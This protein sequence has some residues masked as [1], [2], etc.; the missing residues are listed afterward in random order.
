[1]QWLA[2]VVMKRIV[3]VTSVFASAIVNCESSGCGTA[4]PSKS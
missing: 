2:I 4:T 3:L 1:L